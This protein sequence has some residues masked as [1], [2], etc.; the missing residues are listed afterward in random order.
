M[1]FFK[2]FDTVFGWILIGFLLFGLKSFAEIFFHPLQRVFAGL[3]LLLI[4]ITPVIS[5]YKVI[6]PL[7]DLVRGVFYLYLFWTLTIILRPLFQGVSYSSMSIQPYSVFGITSYL[8]PFIVLLGAG[9]ISLPKLFKI[10]YIFALVGFIYFVVNF[11]NMLAIV[12][13]GV[14][15]YYDDSDA[16]GINDLA[17]RYEFWFGISALS[18]LCYE[19]LTKK[20]KWIAISSVAIMFFLV[21]YFARRGGV[22]IYLGYFVAAFY[23]YFLRSNGATRFL[24]VLFMLL[25][26][27]AITLTVFMYSDTTFSLLFTRGTKDTRG[28]VDESIIRYLNTEKAWF[29]GKGIEGAYPDPNFDEPRYTHETGYLYMILKGGVVYLSLYVFLLLQSAYLGFFKANN[30]LTKAL[31]I[32]L[33]FHVLFLIPFGVIMFGLEYFYVWVAVSI[34]QS[35]KYRIMTNQEMKH[36]LAII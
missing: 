32:Y 20:Q 19:F 7:K 23:L 4:F 18:F 33:V 5:K 31:A 36:F 6:S 15:L 28:E 22:V 16:I 2:Q 26:L 34:C 11:K 14:L 13:S 29:F 12:S 30:R 17:E 35:A 25:I 1:K 27:G 21:L 8:L 24:K 9:I 3:G 10:N